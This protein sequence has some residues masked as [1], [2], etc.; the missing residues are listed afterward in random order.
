MKDHFFKLN[1]QKEK[2]TYNLVMTVEP[3]TD[4]QERQSQ[5][6]GIHGSPN[7]LCKALL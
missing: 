1:N 6:T 4:P 2:D 7:Q 5:G 3:L